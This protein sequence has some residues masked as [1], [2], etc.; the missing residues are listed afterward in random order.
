MS[1]LVAT[2]IY[3]AF[4]RHGQPSIRQDHAFY[5]FEPMNK[6]YYKK[7]YVFQQSLYKKTFTRESISIFT[8]A[9]LKS[10]YIHKFSPF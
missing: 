4:R 1:N 5:T 10:F 6:Y 3:V 2:E 9:F 7:N 8:S